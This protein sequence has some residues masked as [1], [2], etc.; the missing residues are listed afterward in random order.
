MAG[1]KPAKTQKEKILKALTPTKSRP[2]P[3]LTAQQARQRLGV[4]ALSARVTELRDDGYPISIQTYTGENG[5]TL[6]RYVLGV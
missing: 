4:K 3:T 6:V 1:K 5:R 2:H